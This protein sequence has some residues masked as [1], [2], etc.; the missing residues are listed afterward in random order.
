[1]DN[2]I[3]YTYGEYV[4]DREI[5]QEYEKLNDLIDEKIDEI[6]YNAYEDYLDYDGRVDT[7]VSEEEAEEYAD[8]AAD[9]IAAYV[10]ESL[11]AYID[12]LYA[13]YTATSFLQS[14]SD[15]DEPEETEAE[16]D[17]SAEAEADQADLESDLEA[18]YGDDVSAAKSE[19]SENK[20]TARS[21]VKSKIQGLNKVSKI[22]YAEISEV[23]AEIEEYLYEKIDA[24]LDYAIE[25]AYA[26]YE[27]DKSSS[28]E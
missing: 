24:Y 20:Q 15:V 14:S 17:A 25:N 6:A 8:E 5:D 16:K 13:N 1:M 27:A 4:E 12:E 11:D 3:S 10:D 9:E 22:A 28:S 19:A 23:A 26:D 2:L 18:E 21:K 7:D